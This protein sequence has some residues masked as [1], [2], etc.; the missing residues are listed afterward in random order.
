M[1]DQ[2]KPFI[3]AVGRGEKLKRDLTYDESVEAMRMMM[4]GQA[5][6]AQMGAFLISQRVKG[7]AVDEINGFTHLIRDEFVRPLS[8][9]VDEL[10]DLAVPYDGKVKTAQ[11]APAITV[12]L[13]EAGVPVL[14][15][16][17]R[18]VPTKSGVGPGDVL[19]ALGI[20]DTMN[21]ARTEQL[22]E[23]VGFGY[24][25]AI[26]Y[27]PEWHR[28]LPLR[29][30]FGLRTLFN[31]I[32]KFFNPGDAPNQISGFFHANYIERI[33]Q[34]QTGTKQS[35]MVQ[36]EE[37]SIE[38]ASGRK[39]HIFAESSENDIILEPAAVG[40]PEREKIAMA[41]DATAHAKLNFAILAGEDSPALDQAVF[42]TATILSVLRASSNINAG[43]I[44]TRDINAGDISTE[45]AKV[46]E[47]ISSGKA[48]A[49]LDKAR[50]S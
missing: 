48:T 50:Q 49:R 17:D 13:A 32:E 33:R 30:Q 37:G 16:G 45:M 6:D 15:H 5:T 2:F 26:E 23:R 36:G 40:L 24:I 22:I 12:L 38:M 25:S 4:L 18:D 19:A 7:E 14:L 39:S 10:L 46:R 1:S 28:L 43:D 8:P 41:P 27:L 35:W 9:K 20:P 47:S 29:R 11:L 44:N 31:T 42:T 3:K 21:I 34:S